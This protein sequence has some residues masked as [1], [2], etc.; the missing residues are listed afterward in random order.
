MKLTV[1][2]KSLEVGDRFRFKYQ[3]SNQCLYEVQHKLISQTG[4]IGCV[5][6][7]PGYGDGGV[8]HPDTDVIPA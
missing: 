2:L 7:Q 1:K 3:N 4:G 6:V 8:F 5:Q